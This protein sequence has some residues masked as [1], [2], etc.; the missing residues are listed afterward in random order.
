[1]LLIQSAFSRFQRAFDPVM[2]PLYSII[3]IHPSFL[4]YVRKRE[5]RWRG[6]SLCERCVGYRRQTHSSSSGT[7]GS[8]VLHSLSRWRSSRSSWGNS[9]SCLRGPGS[10]PGAWLLTYSSKST[11]S[12][13]SVRGS[14]QRKIQQS[15]MLRGETNI[16]LRICRYVT[17]DWKC[18]LHVVHEP[19]HVWK[20]PLSFQSEKATVASLLT[21]SVS[22]PICFFRGFPIKPKV[23]SLLTVAQLHIDN[24]HS[25]KLTP[26]PS[27]VCST[28]LMCCFNAH[29]HS[30]GLMLSEK[31]AI[32][33]HFWLLPQTSCWQVGSRSIPITAACAT[34]PWPNPILKLQGNSISIWQV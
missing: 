12:T 10:T 25:E 14:C 3:E 31:Q 34:G 26:S 19:K 7:G 21:V 15:W 32:F 28:K 11:G 9:R 29:E 33:T 18:L 8:R 6:G 23:W 5:I 27:L 4:P 2:F 22:Q 16:S 30:S 24:Q 17:L 13:T 1:M 20:M